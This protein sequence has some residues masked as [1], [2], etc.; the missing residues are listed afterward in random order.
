MSLKAFH[1][2]FICVSTVLSAGFGLWA[3]REYL[4]SGDVLNLAMGIGSFAGGTSL[5]WY[6]K[7]FLRKLKH[8]SYL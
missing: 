4:R 7:W 2:F 1:V 6:S 3:V 8:V 5:I